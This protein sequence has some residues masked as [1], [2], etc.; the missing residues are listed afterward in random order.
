M[1]PRLRGLLLAALALLQL[2]AAASSIVRYETTLSSG[3][4]YKI[5]TV[6]FDPA[7]AFRGRYVAVQPAIM[8]TGEVEEPARQLLEGAASGLAAY[9]VLGT[10]DAGFARAAAIVGE[11]PA[12]GDYLPIQSAFR[13]F[14]QPTPPAIE[15][16]TTGYRL[17]FAF[18]RYYMAEAAAPL[19]QDRFSEATRRNSNVAAWLNVR[20]RNGIAV[21]EGL[22]IDGKRIEEVIGGAVR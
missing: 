14:A 11:R 4:L 15:F 3:A 7:D 6:A 13:Q 2:A 22:Y 17:N 19:A 5:R 9:V 16:I 8:I 1:T 20:V 21:I 10:D 12:S 18:D